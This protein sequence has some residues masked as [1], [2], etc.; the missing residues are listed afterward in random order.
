M[1]RH[2]WLLDSVQS[3][4]VLVD[5]QEKII[6]AIANHESIV[7]ECRV[8]LQ[9]ARLLSVPVLVTEQYPKGL[10][11]TM[12]V[13]RNE[14]P[15]AG[16]VEKTTF[17]CC[18]STVFMA[19]LQDQRRRQLVLAG[20]EAHV[21]MMQTALDLLASGYQ[22]HVPVGATGSR[23][24]RNKEI[25]LQRLHAAGGILTTTESVLFEWLA[26]AKHPAFRTVQKLI[27]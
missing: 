27:L 9:A 21:C 11:P 15:D 23:M 1:P 5:V 19:A 7:Q 13:L 18:E 6:P 2:P 24:E 4:V 17:S 20:I 25:A 22:V 12:P 10:G 14:I 3:L 16:C 8:L 26:N